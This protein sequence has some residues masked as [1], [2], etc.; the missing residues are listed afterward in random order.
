MTP[1]LGTVFALL[2]AASF[3]AAYYLGAYQGAPAVCP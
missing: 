2:L 1:R 3:V